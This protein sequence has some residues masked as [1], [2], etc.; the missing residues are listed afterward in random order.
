MG[1]AII[2]KLV[3]GKREIGVLREEG[4]GFMAL[5]APKHQLIH[6]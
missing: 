2:G 6:S 1:K 3:T 5:L 4:G